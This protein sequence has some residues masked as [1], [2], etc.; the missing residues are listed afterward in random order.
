MGYPDGMTQATHDREFDDSPERE[1]SADPDYTGAEVI[2]ST[3]MRPR[4]HVCVG[5]GW[6]FNLTRCVNCAG[7]GYVAVEES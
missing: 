1:S 3:I 6:A 4:C 7:T 5:T 2:A